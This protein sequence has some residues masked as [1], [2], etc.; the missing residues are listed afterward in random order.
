MKSEQEK[1]ENNNSEI[2]VKKYS[3]NT[4]TGTCTQK[5]LFEIQQDKNVK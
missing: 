5:N 2:S 3:E 4:H 1:S